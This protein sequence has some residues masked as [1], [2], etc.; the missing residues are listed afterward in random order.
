MAS[1]VGNIHGA[2]ALGILV[3]APSALI[4][5]PLN[6]RNGSTMPGSL[7][8]R[9]VPGRTAATGSVDPLRTFG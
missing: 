6:H 1:P 7:V 3:S 8:Q 2:F 9:S 4:D 5:Q